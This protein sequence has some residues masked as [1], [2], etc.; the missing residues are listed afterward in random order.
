MRHSKGMSITFMR[1]SLILIPLLF[2]YVLCILLLSCFHSLSFSPSSPPNPSS[3]TLK[4]NA[5]YHYQQNNRKTVDN[6]QNQRTLHCS[7][8]IPIRTRMIWA[9]AHGAWIPASHT[10]TDQSINAVLL[11]KH[12]S[13]LTQINDPTPPGLNC[14]L[15]IHTFLTEEFCQPLLVCIL[16]LQILHC[17]LPSF[18]MNHIRSPTSR[19]LERRMT[20]SKASKQLML[21][22]C[23]LPVT[24]DGWLPFSQ[25]QRRFVNVQSGAWAQAPDGEQIRDESGIT[26]CVHDAPVTW[27]WEFRSTRL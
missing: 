3:H 13:A 1:V 21:G 4:F 19:G 12:R 15:Y 16:H 6:S 2:L 7:A 27:T 24:S 20:S 18:P 9:V 10:T 14:T 5:A 26:T 22:L 17:V 25:V 11:L 8:L 23:L